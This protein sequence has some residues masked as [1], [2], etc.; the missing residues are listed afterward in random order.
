MENRESSKL[1]TYII[2]HGEPQHT[3]DPE[4]RLTQNGINQVRTE[5]NSIQDELSDFSRI[6]IYHSDTER[7]KHTAEVAYNTLYTSNLAPKLVRRPVRIKM[8]NA[9]DGFEAIDAIFR[10]DHRRNSPYS[11]E[12]KEYWK[13]IEMIWR[14]SK[15]EHMDAIH[16]RNPQQVGEE[17]VLEYIQRLAPLSSLDLTES[18]VNIIAANKTLLLGILSL[19]RALD[20]NLRIGYADI[21]KM[22]IYSDTTVVNHQGSSY[23]I[24]YSISIQDE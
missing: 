8:F 23:N 19:F 5:I 3:G 12:R 22:D 9:T 18:V 4:S 15:R 21:L 14:S 1:G 24:D 11:N 20:D 2:R 7:T 10:L 17:I 6:Q 13:E 16:G